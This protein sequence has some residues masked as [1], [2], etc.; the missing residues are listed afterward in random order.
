LMLSSV[1]LLKELVLK[2]KASHFIFN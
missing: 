1:S 2:G